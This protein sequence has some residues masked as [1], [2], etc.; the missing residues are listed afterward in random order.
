MI[1]PVVFLL[2]LFQ[3]K[4]LLLTNPLVVQ[5]VIFIVC[6]ALIFFYETNLITH[7]SSC[8]LKY[9]SYCLKAIK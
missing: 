1:T 9:N 2:E 7:K 3:T 5:G 8:C 6:A 4:V